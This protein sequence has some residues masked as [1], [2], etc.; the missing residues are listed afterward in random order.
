MFKGLENT[1]WESTY[2]VF[3]P[4]IDMEENVDSRL[5]ASCREGR[6]TSGGGKPCSAVCARVLLVWGGGGNAAV[7]SPFSNPLIPPL[8]F[9]GVCGNWEATRWLD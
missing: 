1:N 5:A 8:S 3:G 2:A 7:V 6:K 9:Q 4:A